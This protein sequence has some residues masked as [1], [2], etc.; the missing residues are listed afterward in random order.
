MFEHFDDDARD[1]MIQAEAEASRLNHDYLGT[2]HIVLGLTRG[3]GDAI[4]IL[5]MLNVGLRDI[6]REVEEI[7]PSSARAV[8]TGDVPFTPRAKKALENALEEARHLNCKT[9]GSEHILL[10]LLQ[11]RSTI[12]YQILT[13][14]G[15]DVEQV[16]EKARVL[17]RDRTKEPR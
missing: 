12:A 16:R 13:M 4:V 1:V 3:T 8:E 5:K 10:G 15:L 17:A 2:E 7:V 6:R 9:V 14:L 11:D